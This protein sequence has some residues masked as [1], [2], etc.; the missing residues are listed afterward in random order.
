M[1]NLILGKLLPANQKFSSNLEDYIHLLVP[2][3]VKLLGTIDVN[4]NVRRKALEIIDFFCDTLDLCDFGSH[5]IHPAT[6]SRHRVHIGTSA[7]SY[8]YS[9]IP[10]W[11][12][13]MKS[14]WCKKTRNRIR[15]QHYDV[16]VAKIVNV[17]LIL[18]VDN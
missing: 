10:C 8:R 9:C 4:I 14:R 15:Y 7:S 11:F 3:I 12:S 16:L 6:H 5:I 18:K 13:Y 17:V 1:F 2:P